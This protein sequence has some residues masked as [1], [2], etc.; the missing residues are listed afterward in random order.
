MLTVE[1]AHNNRATFEDKFE[2]IAARAKKLGLS[3]PTLTWGASEW[4]DNGVNRSRVLWHT[5]TVTGEVVA[6]G[7]WKVV[8]AIDLLDAASGA[9]VVR[10]HEAVREEWRHNAARCD[11]CRTVRRRNLTVVV[12]HE[13]GTEKVVGGDCL[14]D[15][16][17]TV[18]RDPMALAVYWNDLLALTDAGGSDDDEDRFGG[19]GID[20]I[21]F[22][23]YLPVVAEITLTTGFVSKR[24][25]EELGGTEQT[26]ASLAFLHAFT[27]NVEERSRIIPSE[28]ACELAKV[29]LEWAKNLAPTSDYEQNIRAIALAGYGTMR[30]MGYIA[31]IVPA[32]QRAVAFQEEK[33]RRAAQVA[34][35]KHVGAVDEKIE[36]RVTLLRVIPIDGFYGTKFLHIFADEA[37]NQLKWFCSGAVPTFPEKGEFAAIKATVTDHGERNGTKETT[38]SRVRLVKAKA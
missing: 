14:R 21:D 36:T 30:H 18:S 32:Y 11:H 38:L 31:S 37:G 5:A 13:D 10:S 3:V 16:A 35:S 20:A 27:R 12:R 26:T 25:A 7:G 24:R 23:R 22:D 33:A 15:F 34:E 19:G 2:R 9:V 4:K 6:F 29:A 8:A 17:P 28:A 1:I